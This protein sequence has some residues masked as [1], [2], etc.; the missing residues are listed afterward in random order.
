MIERWTN[1]IQDLVD[2]YRE[3]RCNRERDAGLAHKAAALK[4]MD[5]RDQWLWSIGKPWIRSVCWSCLAG[6]AVALVILLV[7]LAVHR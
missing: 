2:A 5:R 7:A 3:W 1:H 6:C 4:R